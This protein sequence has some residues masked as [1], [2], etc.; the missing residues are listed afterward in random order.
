MKMIEYCLIVFHINLL[1]K[2]AIIMP[3]ILEIIVQRSPFF[4]M[5]EAI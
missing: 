3:C 5:A 1:K 4:K 2:F